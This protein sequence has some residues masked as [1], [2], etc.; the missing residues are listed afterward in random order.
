MNIIQGLSLILET[1]NFD[2]L[3]RLW[4]TSKRLRPFYNGLHLW[5]G[6]YLVIP[7]EDFFEKAIAATNKRGFHGFVGSPSFLAKALMERNYIDEAIYVAHQMENV[8]P[9]ILAAL[10]MSNGSLVALHSI[11]DSFNIVVERSTIMAWLA[12]PYGMSFVSSELYE[13]FGMWGR[14]TTHDPCPCHSCGG[15]LGFCCLKEETVRN[16]IRFIRFALSYRSEV[17][18]NY[19]LENIKKTSFVRTHSAAFAK[20]VNKSSSTVGEDVKVAQWWGHPLALEIVN[21]FERFR[22]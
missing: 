15:Y 9:S 10:A 7:S 12:N 6:A 13:T 2:G 3:R 19:L 20:E 5:I 14:L 1:L 21:F 16:F 11:F 4:F 8:G 18:L 22:K 17:A